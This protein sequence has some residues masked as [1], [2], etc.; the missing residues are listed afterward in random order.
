LLIKC[1][2]HGGA[3]R[4]L[5]D[6]ARRGDR[7]A[8]HYEAAFVL[9][10]EAG[11]VPAMRSTGTEVHGLGARGNWDLSWVVA[12]RRLLIRRRYDIVHAHLPYA[13][14]FARLVARTLPRGSRPR[15]VYTEHSDW[16]WTATPVRWLNRATI[17]YDD[18]LITVSDSVRDSLP[19]SLQRHAEVIVHGVDVSE[20]AGFVARRCQLRDEVR[21]ELGIQEG[22][23]LVLTVANLRPEK[24]HEVLLQA[25]KIAFDRGIAASFFVVGYGP[26]SDALAVAKSE[27]G[28]G[29]RFTF[30]G[31]REDVL[32]L[33]AAA[34]IFVLPS[35]LEGLPV[36]L[37][38][39]TSVGA[40]VVATSVGEVPR[41]ITSGVDGLVVPPGDAEALTDAIEKLVKDPL[42]RSNLGKAAMDLSDRFDGARAT[43]RIEAIYREVLD[44]RGRPV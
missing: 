16:R 23:A 17:G 28:L 31:R 36:T 27:L 39:A 25:A 30:L 24:G 4:L 13:A 20:S 43:R 7:E 5:V 10:S 19:T 29:D 2:G 32:R 11:L 15:L 12:L 33:M 3:E 37:M 1:L 41:I 35:R 9:R 26:L 18:A 38:E 34:D 44:A 21:R 6:M 22:R 42:M 8:F 14:S 40:A